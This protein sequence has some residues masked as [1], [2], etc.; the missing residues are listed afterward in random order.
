MAIYGYMIDTS[1]HQASK[2]DPV[3]AKASGFEY[4]WARVGFAT[5]KDI[6]FEK[7]YARYKAAGLKIGTYFA[8]NQNTV[9]EAINDANRTLS[10]LAGKQLDLPIA[11]DIERKEQAGVA[12]K[13]INS[14]MYNA[15][16]EVIKKA[17]YKCCLYTGM[18]YFNNYFNASKIKDP[19]WIARY[20]AN[21]G[22]TITPPTGIKGNLCIHQYSS[23]EIHTPF[24]N[25]KLDL[26]IMTEPYSKLMSNYNNGTNEEIILTPNNKS[27]VKSYKGPNVKIGQ[28]ACN[29]FVNAGLIADGERGAKSKA[30]GIKVLQRALN[31]DL[32]INLALTGELDDA[33]KD[34]LNKIPPIKK[35]SKG[36]LV[37]ACEI[38]LY[39]K[40][41]T[42]SGI[43]YPGQFENG[44][45]EALKNFQKSNNLV[46]DGI[47]GKKTFLA[48]VE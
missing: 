34:A 27:T 33:T 23:G 46:V 32:K 21:N 13:D 30:A 22:R 20:G 10:W 19:L 6:C 41:V 7:D 9:A 18:S 24:Y 47:C 14:D 1:K 26:S 45:N 44:C 36:Y 25:G 43:E 15:F 38:L 29:K 11:Y 4:I 16:A 12:R 5:T 2:V 8:T 17:G 40:N 31:Y 48:L 28:Q 37:T 39:L 35:G 42:P 3:A